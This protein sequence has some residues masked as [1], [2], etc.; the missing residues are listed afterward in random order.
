M[1]TAASDG[2]GYAPDPQELRR[3]LVAFLLQEKA[4]RSPAVE[5]AFLAVPREIFL[6]QFPLEKVYSDDAIP[7]KWDANK[8]ATSSSTQPA[9]MADMLETLDVAPGMHVLEIGAGVGYNA[10]IL[11]NLLGETGQL[12]TIDLDPAMAQ[13]A[14]RNLQELA[15]RTNDLVY[16]RVTVVATD[17]SQGFPAHALYDRIIVTVQQW[18]V[19]P[20]WIEQLKPGGKLL[21]PLTLTNHLWGGGGLIPLLEKSND[22]ILRTT[23]ISRGAFMYM[24]GNMSHPSAPPADKSVTLPFTP[25]QI[26]SQADA[27]TRLLLINPEMSAAQLGWLEQLTPADLAPAGTLQLDF[28]AGAPPDNDKRRAELTGLGFSLLLGAA[29]GGQIFPLS[30]ATPAPEDVEADQMPG[31]DPFRSQTRNGWK[32]Q[33]YGYCC[34]P[35]GYLVLLSGTGQP[36]EMRAQSWRI[37]SLPPGENPLA[38]I[39]KAWADW[40]QMGRPNLMQYRPLLYPADQSP[41]VT[42][43]VLP[44]RNYNI[45][46][47]LL[48]G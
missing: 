26:S 4:I 35:P 21:L 40:Q 11:A 19:S 5:R 25:T 38:I 27:Q 23:G 41:P 15:R 18:D 10:A 31:L 43:Y 16:G 22:G 42:G 9:L 8:I 3:G 7:V 14:F 39:Q 30:I 33:L 6:P 48:T 1:S 13:T 2:M 29:F 45:L 34:L 44:R 46:L 12:T 37:T 24:R 28:N 36:G 32:Y 47:P 17:G 20:K